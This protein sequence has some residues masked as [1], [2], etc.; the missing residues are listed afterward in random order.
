MT[1]PAEWDHAVY[2]EPR[3]RLAKIIVNEIVHNAKQA[4]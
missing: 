2:A 1:T 4:M 3:R